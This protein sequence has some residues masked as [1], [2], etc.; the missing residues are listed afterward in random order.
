MQWAKFLNRLREHPLSERDLKYYQEQIIPREGHVY[1]PE[2]SYITLTNKRAEEINHQVFLLAPVEDRYIVN[3]I[4][5]ARP[6]ADRSEQAILDH[7]PMVPLK[8]KQGC[9]DNLEV[10][11]NGSYDVVA[12]LDT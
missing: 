2:V 8:D 11:I 5:K 7:I 6:S 12:N 10:W 3:A 1:D 4:D 9:S